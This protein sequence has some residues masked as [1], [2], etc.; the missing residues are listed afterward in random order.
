M[1]TR[2]GYSLWPRWT[3]A[4]RSA[5]SGSP[6]DIWSICK[7]FLADHQGITQR[8]DFQQAVLIEGGSETGRSCLA[9]DTL[10]S[11]VMAKFKIMRGRW[12]RFNTF[13]AASLFPEISS[14]GD[15]AWYP[16]STI[17][18]LAE[19]QGI[20]VSNV[21]TRRQYRLWTRWNLTPKPSAAGAAR[22]E[23]GTQNR[24]FH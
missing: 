13:D 1:M 23:P 12:H 22:R 14:A 3:R 7:V 18:R 5:S 8:T 11:I 24:S 17:G 9:V 21:S 2:I 10:P 15:S 20:F 16:R 19:S 4:C 6:I